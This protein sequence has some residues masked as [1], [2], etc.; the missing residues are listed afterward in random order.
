[1]TSSLEDQDESV[2]LR[3]TTPRSPVDTEQ[4]SLFKNLTAPLK[5]KKSQNPGPAFQ[6]GDLPALSHYR[7]LQ[8]MSPELGGAGREKRIHVQLW[9]DVHKRTEKHSSPSVLSRLLT[10]SHLKERINENPCGEIQ[11]PIS[12]SALGAE[13][14]RNY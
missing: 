6:V 1:M 12:S 2:S 8:I 9:Q 4:F 10:K 13:A 3:V 5:K 7:P 14:L 11:W